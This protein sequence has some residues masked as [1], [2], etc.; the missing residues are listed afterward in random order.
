MRRC[1]SLGINIFSVVLQAVTAGQL[2]QKKKTTAAAVPSPFHHYDLSTRSLRAQIFSLTQ[3]VS[4]VALTNTPSLDPP[5]P[6]AQRAPMGAGQGERLSP[7]VEMRPEPYTD[8][9]F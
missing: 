3:N 6:C 5:P 4:I 9:P 7:V 1:A 2:I 8:P